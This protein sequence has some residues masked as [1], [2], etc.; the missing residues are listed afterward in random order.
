MQGSRGRDLLL[1]NRQG[2]DGDASRL[3]MFSQCMRLGRIGKR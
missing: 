1:T 2:Y 3:G